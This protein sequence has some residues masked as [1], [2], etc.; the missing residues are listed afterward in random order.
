MVK[1]ID[2]IVAK[3][4]DLKK[5]YKRRLATFLYKRIVS[6]NVSRFDVVLAAVWIQA[7]TKTTRLSFFTFTQNLYF[8]LNRCTRTFVASFWLKHSIFAERLCVH[9]DKIRPHIFRF[10]I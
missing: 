8:R 4:P 1:A 3:F 10:F 7:S 5:C 2:F 6:E 9:L